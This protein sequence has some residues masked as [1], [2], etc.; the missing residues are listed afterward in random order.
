MTP[1]GDYEGRV[2]RFQHGATKNG[3]P[4]VRLYVVL[5][6][7]AGAVTTDVF[8]LDRNGNPDEA[9]REK[10]KACGWDGKDVSRLDGVTANLVP[11]RVVH[12]PY[13]TQSGASGIRVNAYLNTF[14]LPKD[15]LQSLV[16]A[17]RATAPRDHDDF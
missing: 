6:N 5:E 15:K 7:N 8:L 14:S 4:F 1:E 3:S 17:F 10:L 13:T 2:S 16:Q 9:S 12:K 11:V